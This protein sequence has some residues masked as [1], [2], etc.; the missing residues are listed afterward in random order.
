M[1]LFSKFSTIN[2]HI[3]ISIELNLIELNFLHNLAE[4]FI[5]IQPNYENVHVLPLRLS[6]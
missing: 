6:M 3:E 4:L 5:Q 2:A 1:F